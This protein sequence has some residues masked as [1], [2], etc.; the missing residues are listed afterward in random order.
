M[1]REMKGRVFLS[2]MML[3]FI[4]SYASASSEPSGQEGSWIP[5]ATLEVAGTDTGFL[6]AE[7]RGSSFELAAVTYPEVGNPASLQAAA[8]AN[9]P[10]A[11]NDESG[12]PS[13]GSFILDN[14]RAMPSSAAA[15]WFGSALLGLTIVARR[16][17]E[18][19]VS[20]D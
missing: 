18:K 6:S 4:G 17:D 11:A 14:I 3:V 12:V 13:S 15:W 7:T 9:A 5:S 1:E 2:A 16:R 20:D 10:M 8:T 19:R